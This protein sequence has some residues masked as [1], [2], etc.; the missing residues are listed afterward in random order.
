MNFDNLIPTEA[1]NRQGADLALLLERHGQTGLASLLATARAK[2]AQAKL[3]IPVLGTAKRGKSTLVNALLGRA[4][5]TLAPVGE[6]QTSNVCTRF[7]KGPETRVTVHYRNGESEVVPPTA[8][9]DFVTEDANPDNCRGVLELS[10][11]SPDFPLPAGIVLMDTPGAGSLIDHHNEFILRVIPQ[12]DAVI[13]LV[14]AGDPISATEQKLLRDLKKEQIQKIL[15]VVNMKDAVTPRELLDGIE[16]NRR[17][18]SG[19]G[20]QT[21]IRPISARMALNDLADSGVPEV[22]A[23]LAATGLK[24]RLEL[25]TAAYRATI[26]QVAQSA[27]EALAAE[28]RL[29]GQ[30][31]EELARTRE[32]LT[33]FRQ[34]TMDKLDFH[35]ANFLRETGQLLSAFESALPR[36]EDEAKRRVQAHLDRVIGADFGS[37]WKK[38]FQRDD[39]SLAGLSLFIANA[40]E[41]ELEAPAKT[42]ADGL[43][44]AFG[45]LNQDIATM[46]DLSG[47]APRGVNHDGEST[48]STLGHYAKPAAL[49]GGA[50]VA[51]IA[52]TSALASATAGVAASAS[53]AV[54]SIPLIGA[55]LSGGAG[56][57][58]A[59]GTAAALTPVGLLLTAGCIAIGAAGLLGLPTAWRNARLK[60]K[61]A[62]SEQARQV[63]ADTFKQ[64]RGE[65]VPLLRQAIEDTL[66]AARDAAQAH[67]TAHEAAVARAE[68]LAGD[69]SAP[70]R[71]QNAL[72]EFAALRKQLPASA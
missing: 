16:H 28:L 30:G 11:T 13:Y 65:R 45:R 34:A 41:T 24:Q 2:H 62:F 17:I 51:N 1:L 22:L 12:A 55:W 43:G 23:E 68:K 20:I 10:V 56:A 40:C 69:P 21:R 58:A 71:L 15:F 53:G 67:L 19:L 54:A 70:L 5:D 42:L 61:E 3:V 36:V 52:A 32:E 57:T 44:R 47:V 38:V 26:D 39:Q 64:L 27:E 49:I 9:R 35:E 25:K 29:T 48:L 7:E 59:V 18:L 37:F 33:R 8:I 14:T 72:D 60:T 31:R 66:R 50:F 4:D 46:P 6:L 63:V